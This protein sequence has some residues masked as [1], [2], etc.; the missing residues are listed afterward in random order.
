MPC[1]AVG[2]VTGTFELLLPMAMQSLPFLL[3]IG[4]RGQMQFQRRRLQDREHLLAYKRVQPLAGE[5]L[6][7]RLT[8]VDGTPQTAVAQAG[9]GVD[10]LNQQAAAALATHQ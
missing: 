10:V 1:S 4:G 6:T 9:A 7:R 5:A 8:V 3:D 2:L